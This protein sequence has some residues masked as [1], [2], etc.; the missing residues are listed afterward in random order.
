[1]QE[2]ITVTAGGCSAL[3]RKDVMQR[4]YQLSQIQQVAKPYKINVRQR[5][6]V[7]KP[8]TESQSNGVPVFEGVG[9]DGLPWLGEAAR[10]FGLPIAT[11]IMDSGDLPYFLKSLDPI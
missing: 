5:E 10:E 4:A 9:P 3:T 8:R 6:C 2:E 11:E 7:Y 1:M